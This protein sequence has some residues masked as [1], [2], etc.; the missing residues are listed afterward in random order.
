MTDLPELRRAAQVL[1]IETPP[2]AVEL[3]S[4]VSRAITPTTTAA[5]AL[6]DAIRA[7]ASE[8][9]RR[10][11]LQAAQA[12][13]A[14]TLRDTRPLVAACDRYEFRSLLAAIGDPVEAARER[15][16]A[17]A[18]VVAGASV[19]AADLVL[20][21]NPHE[22]PHA[23]VALMSQPGR[24][25]ALGAV[26]EA[27]DT[28]D[29]LFAAVGTVLAATGTKAQRQGWRDGRLFVEIDPAFDADAR[30]V[31]EHRVKNAVDQGRC[32]GRWSM[33]FAIEGVTPRLGTLAEVTA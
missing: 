31:I 12:E 28:L 18:E 11:L 7:G 32:S 14:S 10:R 9:T 30:R 33:L 8:A 24:V 1:G 4:W 6:A 16:E 13:A 2:K 3:R 27:S 19:G 15:W 22:R 5:D 26:Q 23:A 20:A 21:A 25:A 29:G 17:A